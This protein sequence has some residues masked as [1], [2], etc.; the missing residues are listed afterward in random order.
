MLQAG[1]YLVKAQFEG[2]NTW[3]A[4]T[5][6]TT[7][8]VGPAPTALTVYAGTPIRTSTPT[9]L[10]GQLQNTKTGKP[11]ADELTTLTISAGGTVVQTLTATTDS[12]GHYSVAGSWKLVGTWTVTASFPGDSNYGSSNAA[13]FTVT[14][15][16][17]NTPSSPPFVLTG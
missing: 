5:T 1:T 2:D 3:A 9:T 10:Y 16:G 4:Q 11:V 15:S 6:T 8:T 13:P 12:S 14:V 7:V 17:T